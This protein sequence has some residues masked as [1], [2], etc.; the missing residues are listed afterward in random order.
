M[1]SGRW[2]VFESAM[3]F[4][5]NLFCYFKACKLTLVG[6]KAIFV[7]LFL[8]SMFTSRGAVNCH[9]SMTLVSL[10]NTTMSATCW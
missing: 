2:D 8:V 10:L 9:I 6:G 7:F 5:I 1:A 4:V 3:V